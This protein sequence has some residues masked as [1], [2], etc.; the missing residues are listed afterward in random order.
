MAFW[1]QTVNA[2]FGDFQYNL[3]IRG[4]NLVPKWSKTVANRQRGFRSKVIKFEE[5]WAKSS[6]RFST[7]WAKLGPKWS[8]TVNAKNPKIDH[9][10]QACRKWMRSVR[11]F[12]HAK[13]VKIGTAAQQS[14]SA[15]W[16]LDRRIFMHLG[17]WVSMLSSVSRLVKIP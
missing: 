13:T 12:C 17:H 15:P 7:F 16:A 6:T 8:K 11:F 4:P 2:V 10:W 9:F 1:S 3:H 5:Y 14:C